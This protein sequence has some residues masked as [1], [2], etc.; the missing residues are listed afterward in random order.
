M[1][2]VHHNHNNTEICRPDIRQ[3]NELFIVEIGHNTPPPNYASNKNVRDF[4]VIHYIVSGKGCYNGIMMDGPCLWYGTPGEMMFYT[5]DK[6]PKSPQFEQ[7]WI[8][9]GGSYAPK[10]MADVGFPNH[11]ALLPCPYIFQ[12]CQIIRELQSTHYYLGKDDNLSM[13]AGLYQLM[14]FHF[15]Q[16]NGQK[17]QYSDRV[18]TLINHIHENY[19]QILTEDDLAQ[20]IH[21][22]IRYMHRIFKRETGISPIQYLNSYRIHCAKKLL[23]EDNLSIKDVAIVSGFTTHNYFCAVFRKHSNGM[24]PLEYRKAYRPLF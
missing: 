12:A 21:L 19:A 24:S 18:Q 2:K 5:V 20:K 15:T 1:Y 3:N 16:I 7:Y 8:I 4:F 23:I 14:S 10:L 6:N 11:L 13:V 17:K 22:S 9:F